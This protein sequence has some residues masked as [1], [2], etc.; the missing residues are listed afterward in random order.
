[1]ETIWFHV[2]MDAFYASVEQLDRPEYRGK[3]VIV[4]G[5]GNR[6]VV[7]ACSYEARAFKVHSA[8]PMYLAR[9]LCPHA[10][11]VRG[12]MDRYN[13]VSRQVISILGTFSPVVQQISI[14]E[15]FLDMSGTERLFGK[16]REAAI[17][18]KQRI[19]EET[20]LYISVGIG[21]SRF[22]AK[23]A[24]DY[25]KPD[26]LCR[27][28]RGKEIAF[29][30]A[31][32]LKK[33][34][35]IGD[36]TLSA[37]SRH[38]ITTTAELRSYKESRL[39]AMFGEAA[40]VYLWKVCRGIDPGIHPGVT[41]SRSISTEMTFPVDV[42]EQ[43]VLEQNLLGMS[44]EVMF[45]AIAEQVNGSTVV[46]KLRFSDFTTINAQATV[47][48]PIY[49]AEQVYALARQLLHTKWPPAQPVRLLGVGLHNV[50]SKASAVQQELFD[51]QYR[52]KGKL[53]KTVLELRAKG[54]PLQ[55]ASLLAPKD[56]DRG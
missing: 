5:L 13:Q 45:R 24:S 53:E 19:K 52:R 30:D 3:P 38:H 55:K 39:R 21:A 41:K 22:I 11:F 33:L 47:D 36:S 28:S 34:W 27:V 7:S 50:T 46:I 8:M 12:R 14:D 9:K 35:G 31:V 32:G 29:V 43:D 4:G 20:G 51:D 48:A 26:G 25:D 1:M 42:S 17:L 6:G 15:A 54:K 44:H 10:I 40:G 2:D 37:L 49:S 56:M 23:M 16:P 18:L